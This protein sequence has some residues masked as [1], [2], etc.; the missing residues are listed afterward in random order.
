MALLLTSLRANNK[1][2]TLVFVL[3]E[4]DLF[5]THHNQSLLYNLFDLAHGNEVIAKQ[6]FEAICLFI[7]ALFPEFGV[8][9]GRDT[10]F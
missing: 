9:A 4:A 3:E 2:K 6:T 7:F 8:C 10:A 5:C 1:N